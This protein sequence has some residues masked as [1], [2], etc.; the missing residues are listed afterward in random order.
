LDLKANTVSITQLEPHTARY[1]GIRT[2]DPAAQVSM[3]QL[4]WQEFIRVRDFNGGQ[5]KLDFYE[6]KLT[7]GNLKPGAVRLVGVHRY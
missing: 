4:P 7:L 1:F 3:W 2:E 5:S 6:R